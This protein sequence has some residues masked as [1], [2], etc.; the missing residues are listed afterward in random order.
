MAQR[1]K[2]AHGPEQGFVADLPRNLAWRR[3]RTVCPP[4]VQP[5]VEELARRMRRFEVFARLP[6]DILLTLTIA[7]SIQVF[8]AGEYLWRQGEPNRRVLFIEQGLAKTSRK[9]LA[10]VA[11]TYGLYGPGDSMGIYAIWTGMQYPTDA[12]A[13]NDS[14]TALLL[15]SAALLKCAQKQPLLAAP[16]LAEIGRFTEAFI[17]KIDIVSA[18]TVPQRMAT[19]MTLL[20]ERF[21]TSNEDGSA[22]LPI[23]LTLEHMGEIVDARVETVSRVLSRW[24]MQDLIT[25]GDDGFQF[26]HMDKIR[27]LL[28]K[29]M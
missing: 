20:V 26:K 28:P 2:P 1:K 19:L 7:A 9:N 6:N 25:V 16:L 3:K 14:M 12:V 13:M 27:A 8:R 29:D 23:Y 11:R 24:K 4:P 17:R 15:D 21:G 22:R 10:G 18:G 5:S